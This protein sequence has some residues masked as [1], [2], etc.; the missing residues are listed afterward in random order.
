MVNVIG[1]CKP[2]VQKAADELA[3]KFGIK[4]VGGYRPG[5]G[6]YGRRD[7][8]LGLALDLMCNKQQGDGLAA[9][10][11]ANAGRLNIYYIIWWRK[12]W[13]V[14]RASEGWRSYSG[15]NPHTDH[16][17]I[18]FRKLG[19]EV[20]GG[21]STGSGTGIPTIPDLDAVV[22][23]SEWL[24][25]SQNWVRVGIFLAG[26]GLLIIGILRLI[27]SSAGLQTAIGTVAKTAKK[28]KK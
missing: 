26:A 27:S 2:H 23:A 19:D 10:A 4:V 1:G 9:Y 25:N 21:G 22:K 3:P 28:V 6:E 7:H 17:H 11:H 13:N 18:S 8:P 14:E 15:A 20:P 24:T 12:I 16:V 5:I